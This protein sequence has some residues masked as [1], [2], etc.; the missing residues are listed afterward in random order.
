MT[1]DGDPPAF[2]SRPGLNVLTYDARAHLDAVL[3]GDHAPFYARLA[4]AMAGPVLEAG[5]GT[6][7]VSL[8]M[9]EAGAP[10]VL[11]LEPS[12]ALRAMAFA[13]RARAP[14]A[15]AAR[16]M[17][18]AG[19]MRTLALWRRFDLITVPF[20]GLQELLNGADLEAALEALAAHLPVGGCL[21][22]DLFD[23]TPENCGP[24]TDPDPIVLPLL[25]HP[26]RGRVRVTALSRQ[27]VPPAQILHERWRFEH[28]VEGSVVAT[29]EEVLS[30]RW[31]TVAEMHQRFHRAGLTPIALYRDFN[32]T[33]YTP[34]YQQVWV[35]EK[36]GG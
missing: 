21:A 14:A 5:S 20:R 31:A 17:F 19:D 3:F 7:R 12:D 13:A 15:L 28:L 29:E 35:L 26:E 6:G 27:P 24:E 16:V 22:C 11:G 25:P 4:A 9:A 8:A 30:L 1:L 2:W 18:Q 33:P 34:G 23:P 32:E 36:T 10:S